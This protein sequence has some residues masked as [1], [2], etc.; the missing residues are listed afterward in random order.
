MGEIISVVFNAFLGIVW[1]WHKNLVSDSLHE[2]STGYYNSNAHQKT[3]LNES[4]TAENNNKTI[5]MCF[6]HQLNSGFTPE[7]DG[8]LQHQSFLMNEKCNLESG[9]KYFKGSF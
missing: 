7:Q 8:L 5:R 4:V 2:S 6:L 9:I 3:S 1:I